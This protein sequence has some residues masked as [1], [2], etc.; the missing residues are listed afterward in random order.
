MIPPPRDLG[1]DTRL[2]ASTRAR[3]ESVIRDEKGARRLPA[4]RALVEALE[5][6]DERDVWWTCE[7]SSHGPVYLLPTREWMRALVR[8]LRGRGVRRILEVAA[9]DGFLSDCLA[10]AA[11]EIEVR[12]CDDASWEQAR[13]RMSAAERRALAGMRVP[14]LGLGARVERMDAVKA[15][16]KHRPDL[17]IVSWAPP[18]DLVARLIRSPVRDVLEVGTDG[19]HCG[20]GPETLRF[21]TEFLEGAVER[22]ALCR[23]DSRPSRERSTRLTL[24]AGREHPEHAALRRGR[25]EG[26]VEFE[27]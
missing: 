26:A 5:A 9:G 19:D 3:L 8:W 22:R 23:L 6:C 1:R 14:G 13:A 25:R 10:A 4:E 2:R 16:R 20:G 7:M 18:G 15:V 21:A 24:Y 12:A 17:V 27:M 11:P